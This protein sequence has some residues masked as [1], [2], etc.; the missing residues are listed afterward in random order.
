MT[1]EQPP[2]RIKWNPKTVKHRAKA[3]DPLDR[4][5][6]E[7]MWRTNVLGTAFQV[8]WIPH[9]MWDLTPHSD[10]TPPKEKRGRWELWCTFEERDGPEFMSILLECRT[11]D[12][13]LEYAE[14][15]IN[16]YFKAK[17]QLLLNQIDAIDSQPV[18]TQH[19]MLV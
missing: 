19:R 4:D 10:R 13:A 14:G 9:D 11:P 15:R 18:G 1:Q 12:E 7:T 8:G 2:L 17:R 5:W 16:M 3:N 6:E